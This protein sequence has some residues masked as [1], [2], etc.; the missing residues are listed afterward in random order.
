[1]VWK[2]QKRRKYTY[3]GGKIQLKIQYLTSKFLP[4]HTYLFS[5]SL[6]TVSDDFLFLPL[7]GPAVP[8][9][10]Q[11]TVQLKQYT[12]LCGVVYFY[13]ECVTPSMQLH[14]NVIRVLRVTSTTCCCLLP[15][16][17]SPSGSLTVSSF[18]DFLMMPQS[19][20]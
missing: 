9:F 19:S 18:Q 3:F 8:L 2:K 10:Q 16:S 1:M 7:T 20:G 11:K 12:T 6:L 15:L 5:A 17:F 13:D 14:L 4:A